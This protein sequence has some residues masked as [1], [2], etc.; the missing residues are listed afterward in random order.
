MVSHIFVMFTPKL[1]YLGEMNPLCDGFF[2]WLAGTTKDLLWVSTSNFWGVYRYS[3]KFQIALPTTKMIPTW[4][5]KNQLF[6]KEQHLPNL[7]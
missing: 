1:G 6:E 7:H 3:Q 5:L 2:K 4:N